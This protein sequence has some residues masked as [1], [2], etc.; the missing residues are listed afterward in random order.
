MKESIGFGIAGCGEI[1]VRT[2]QAIDEAPNC[3]VAATMDIK[4][5]LAR[6][7]GEKY[8]APHFTDFGRMLEC[9]DVDAVYIAAPHFLH[10]PLTIQAARA[11][12]HVLVEKPIATKVENAEAM[13]DECRKSG[14]KLSVAFIMR[15][16][17]DAIEA[18]RLIQ[19]G[20]IG[21]VIGLQ[22]FAVGDKKDS[23]WEGGYSGRA[24]T[25]WRK[26]KEKSGGGILIMNA[27]HNIDLMRF[28]TGLEARR[29]SAHYSTMATDVEVE[30]IIS[31]SIL[32]ENGAIGNISATSCARGGQPPAAKLQ[33]RIF[34]SEGQIVLGGKL[35]VYTTRDYEGLKRGEWQEVPAGGGADGRR[36]FV[37]GVAAALLEG[38]EPPVR[39]EDGLAAL[40]IICAAYESG[41]T[42]KA[43]EI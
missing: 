23:Y 3:R 35:L 42:G 1:A 16:R 41:K 24:K 7:L 43:V 8:G 20:A 36:R 2:A 11:G 34:G 38:K 31:A 5:E 25:D 27:V 33:D 6:D 39:G 13:I 37:E 30:D 22:I 14:V 28:I 40:K 17:N 15:Y 32:F 21:E 18:R 12:K 10:A 19:G 9:D 26:S 29:V 4:E